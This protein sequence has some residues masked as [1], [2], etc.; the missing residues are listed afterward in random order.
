M[1]SWSNDKIEGKLGYALR[2]QSARLLTGRLAAG[3]G[4]GGQRHED[5]GG[6]I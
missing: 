2:R 4:M 6:E 5:S 3:Q 1:G